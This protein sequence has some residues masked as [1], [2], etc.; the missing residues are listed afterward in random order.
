MSTDAAPA[1]DD[2]LA[3]LETVESAT[4]ALM[5]TLEGLEDENAHSPTG[6]PGWTRAHVL[7]HLARNADGLVNLLTWART[8]LE[9]PMYASRSQR[10]ADIEAGAD[11]SAKALRDDVDRSHLRLMATAQGLPVECW[12]APILW[13]KEDNPGVAAVVPKLRQVEVEV[14]HVDLNL[15][16]TAADWPAGFVSRLLHLTTAD[17][18]RDDG[19]SF[20]LMATDS[21]REYAVGDAGPTISGRSASLLAWLIGRGD[22]ADLHVEPTGPLPTLG[23]WR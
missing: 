8:G 20:V 14:H 17:Q 19:Q 4:A 18:P 2:T 6:L 5:R 22:G 12:A 13:G 3:W 15:G 9:T 10:N 7:T 1:H 16:Y 23:A 11:R 21:G